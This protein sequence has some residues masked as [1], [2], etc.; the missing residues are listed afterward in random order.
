MSISDPQMDGIPRRAKSNEILLSSNSL[1]FQDNKAQLFHLRLNQ[2]NSS[3]K[4][5]FFGGNSV[6]FGVASQ[7]PQSKNSEVIHLI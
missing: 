3:C 7:T 1:F 4:R 6:A 2:K 5:Y